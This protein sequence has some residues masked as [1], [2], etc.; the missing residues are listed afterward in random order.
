MVITLAGGKRLIRYV[1]TCS[2]LAI[3]IYAELDICSSFTRKI[4]G[5]AYVTWKPSHFQVYCI[6][7][8]IVGCC[9]R[10]LGSEC[11]LWNTAGSIFRQWVEFEGGE[12]VV[13]VENVDEMKIYSSSK[14][15]SRSN[16]GSSRHSLEDA[17]RACNWNGFCYRIPRSC[18]MTKMSS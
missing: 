8:I 6:F 18:G 3:Y 14:T 1:G 13:Q 4:G 7:K 12:R 10:F 2:V 17:F 16:L 5:I 9:L 15:S 11:S